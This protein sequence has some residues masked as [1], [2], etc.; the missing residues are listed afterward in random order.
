MLLSGD[1]LGRTQQGNNNAYCQD[2]EVSWLDWQL[3]PEDAELLAFVRH[4]M[5]C[6]K[7]TPRSADAAFSRSSGYAEKSRISSG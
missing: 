5:I 6:A 4:M 3:T 2:N 1:Q 7:P